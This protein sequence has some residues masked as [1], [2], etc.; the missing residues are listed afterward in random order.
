MAEKLTQAQ[1]RFLSE[2][3]S[4]GMD[5]E[6]PLWWEVFPREVVTVRAL[7]NRGLVNI[8]EKEDSYYGGTVLVCCIVLPP[9][10][11]VEEWRSKW[12]IPEVEDPVVY[13]ES[14]IRKEKQ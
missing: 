13:S 14:E 2:I 12:S 6:S 9:D 4:E 1:I 8:E 7:A 3:A 11:T 5:P 10:M